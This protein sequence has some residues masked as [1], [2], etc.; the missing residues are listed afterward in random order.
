MAE[1]KSRS[2]SSEG[3]FDA[4]SL[5]FILVERART[6]DLRGTEV[7]ATQ[8]HKIHRN[9]VACSRLRPL[10]STNYIQ[11]CE[12]WADTIALPPTSITVSNSVLSLYLTTLISMST[13]SLA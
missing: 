8:Y 13:G 11:K 12:G 1:R 7:D 9:S 10:E 2:L 5:R 4:A 6:Y 3:S